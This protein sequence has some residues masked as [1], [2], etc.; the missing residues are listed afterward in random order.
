MLPGT[1][2]A[3]FTD[4]IKSLGIPVDGVSGEGPGCRIDLPAEATA[5]Q[6]E[7]ARAA[8]RTFDWNPREHKEPKDILAEVPKLTDAQRR[9]VLD[10]MIADYLADRMSLAADV[11]INLFKGTTSIR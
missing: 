1:P 2:A 6:R 3:R 5:E 8:A 9:L 11:G 7:A 4:H 10:R